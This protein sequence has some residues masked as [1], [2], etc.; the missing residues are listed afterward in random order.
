MLK[1]IE[2]KGFKHWIFWL[3]SRYRVLH[4]LINLSAQLNGVADFPELNLD[5]NIDSLS[6]KNQPLGSLVSSIGY[7]DQQ[8]IA[9]IKLVRGVLRKRQ[10]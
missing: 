5:L 10:T 1:N 3:A 4:G 2:S 6:Y 9:D 8:L 7:A